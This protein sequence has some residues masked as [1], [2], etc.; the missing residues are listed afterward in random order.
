MTTLE[1]P[2]IRTADAIA[3]VRQAYANPP[4]E[5][6]RSITLTGQNAARFAFAEALLKVTVGLSED[7]AAEFILS[8]G[9]TREVQRFSETMGALAAVNQQEDKA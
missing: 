6:T 8:A 5:I 7:E 1:K 3:A 4:S 9:A 2:K